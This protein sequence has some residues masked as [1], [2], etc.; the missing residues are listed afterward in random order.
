MK[1]RIR[2][3]MIFTLVTTFSFGQT[4]STPYLE[5]NRSQLGDI[6]FVFNESDKSR[7]LF[8]KNHLPWW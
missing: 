6:G 2:F 8:D 7:L 5:L 3:L 4:D 1:I